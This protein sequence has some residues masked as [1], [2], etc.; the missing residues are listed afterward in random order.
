MAAGVEQDNNIRKY[1]EIGT[2]PAANHNAIAVAVA[3]NRGIGPERK[4]ARL[5]YLR[6][7]WA[8]R[9]LAASDRVKMITAI[10][11]KTNGAIGVF[12]IDG[13]DMGKLGEWLLS[14]HNIVTTPLIND[15]FQ[16]IRI[17]PNVYTTIDEVD[18]FADRV[19]SAI[20][21]GIA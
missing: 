3:F 8:D 7:R 17:T 18:L 14:K 11:P 15:E 2:H 16:G 12:G 13:M 19:I 1:E 9:L 21:T 5:R 4:I 6:D 10:G 20:R